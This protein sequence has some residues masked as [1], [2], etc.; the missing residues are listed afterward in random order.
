MVLPKFTFL[1]NAECQLTPLPF[2]L[3]PVTTPRV[4]ES[5]SG[6][7]KLSCTASRRASGEPLISLPRTPGQQVPAETVEALQPVP[8][9]VPSTNVDWATAPRNTPKIG[10]GTP[11]VSSRRKLS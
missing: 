11:V 2:F 10:A 9:I 8:P 4:I 7:L 1:S 3:R 5:P 6:L